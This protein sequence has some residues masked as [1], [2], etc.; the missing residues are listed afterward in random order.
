MTEATKSTELLLEYKKLLDEQILKLRAE[1]CELAA[2][3]REIG[4]LISA[5]KVQEVEEQK[6]AD[7]G[8]SGK[9]V[10]TLMKGDK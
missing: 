1:A 6:E 4:K 2:K 3:S 7:K 5:D 10:F 8:W 9:G